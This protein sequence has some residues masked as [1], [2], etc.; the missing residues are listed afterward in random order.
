LLGCIDD[1]RRWVVFGIEVM[2]LKDSWLN[3]GMISL[4]TLFL[5]TLN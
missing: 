4:C 1:L 5:R 3:G 2:A